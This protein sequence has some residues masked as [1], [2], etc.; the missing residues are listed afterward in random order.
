MYQSLLWR[1]QMALYVFLTA[2][3]V[4]ADQ[5]IKYWASTELAQVSTLPL[6]NGVFHLTYVENTGAAFSMLQGR[7]LFF[8]AITIVAF[9]VFVYMFSTGMIKGRLGY[10]SMAFIAGG[11]IGN[12]IDRLRLG[13]VVDLFDFRFINFPVFNFADLCITIGAI[14]F[15]LLAY[16][17]YKEE[18]SKE[19]RK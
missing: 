2:L 11:A 7:R 16:R 19:A 18:K 3:M 6:I 15:I 17:D 14:L 10:Y 12:F 8:I 4:G 1:R 5:L 9:G 13:Y